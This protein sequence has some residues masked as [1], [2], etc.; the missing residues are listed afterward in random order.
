MVPVRRLA[1]SCPRRR[2]EDVHTEAVDF[3]ALAARGRLFA[4][5][6]VTSVEPRT[7]KAW[8]GPVTRQRATFVKRRYPTRQNSEHAAPWRDQRALTVLIGESAIRQASPETRRILELSTL[9]DCDVTAAHSPESPPDALWVLTTSIT[10]DPDEGTRSGCM[11]RAE[12]TSVAGTGARRGILHAEKGLIEWLVQRSQEALGPDEARTLAWEMQ[13]FEKLDF[14]LLVVS[15]S[16][17]DHLHEIGRHRSGDDG[18]LVDPRQALTI[19]ETYLRTRGR[20]IRSIDQR[21]RTSTTV[22]TY[23]ADLAN[24]QMPV[25]LTALRSCVSPNRRH[26]QPNQWRQIEAVLARQHDLC[27]ATQ[28]LR[29]LHFEEGYLGGNFALLSQQLYHLHSVLALAVGTLDIMAGLVADVT[30]AGVPQGILRSWSKMLQRKEK[31]WSGAGQ[32]TQVA[33]NRAAEH[34]QMT[35]LKLVQALRNVYQHNGMVDAALAEFHELTPSGKSQLIRARFSIVMVDQALTTRADDLRDLVAAWEAG[36]VGPQH[37]IHRLEGPSTF[38]AIPHQLAEAVTWATARVAND[39]LHG[40]DPWPHADWIADDVRPRETAL[41]L[42]GPGIT[43]TAKAR[44]D[45]VDVPRGRS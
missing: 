31:A 5:A 23:Y 19:I 26:D 1:V 33:I 38:I 41:W 11:Y 3:E 8:K 40:L 7:A 39:V 34:T 24:A 29:R 13:T 10:P 12:V 25:A 44:A 32:K 22:T 9:D 4:S 20:Y 15:P 18:G 2:H 36:T 16:T 30:G 17:A 6:V 35:F 28:N 37:G 27:I 14:D 42:W 21:M 43:P 45:R